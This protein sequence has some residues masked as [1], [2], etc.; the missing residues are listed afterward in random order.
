M[1]IEELVFREKLH[2]YFKIFIQLNSRDN[3]VVNYFPSGAR[4]IG[5]ITQPLLPDRLGGRQK[6]SFEDLAVP[7]S[8]GRCIVMMMVMMMMSMV[9]TIMGTVLMVMIMLTMVMFLVIVVT[10]FRLCLPISNSAS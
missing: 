2:I 5:G 3:P 9:M 4:T 10:L 1:I 8:S 7:R 6:C